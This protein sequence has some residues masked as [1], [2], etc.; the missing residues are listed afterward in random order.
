MSL[1]QLKEAVLQAAWVAPPPFNVSVVM[2]TTCNL[3]VSLDSWVIYFDVISTCRC[4][5]SLH[6]I[7]RSMN[8]CLLQWGN[9][10]ISSDPPRRRSYAVLFHACSNI[11]VPVPV[12]TFTQIS[13]M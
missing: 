11:P 7:P 2:L 3:R 4:A 8:S 1:K 6:G 9:M 13:L 12:F 5:G 10:T